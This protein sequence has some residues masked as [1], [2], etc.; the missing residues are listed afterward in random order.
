MN[1]KCLVL[2]DCYSRKTRQAERKYTP[3]ELELLAS[4][5][6]LVQWRAFLLRAP[7]TLH[8]DCMLVKNLYKNRGKRELKTRLARLIPLL[9]EYAFD[10]VHLPGDENIFS[11]YLSR[12]GN[13]IEIAV[14]LPEPGTKDC[15]AHDAEIF[16]C[17][18]A[19]VST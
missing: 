6:A 15:V 8:T 1:E 4:K 7:F 5:M 9:A 10:V 12:C 17:L 14:P 18:L 2:V 13:T 3:G 11:D 19:N 16:C